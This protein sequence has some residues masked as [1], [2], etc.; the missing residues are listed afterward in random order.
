MTSHKLRWPFL[1][2]CIL[3]IGVGGVAADDAEPAVKAKEPT[4]GFLKMLEK[5]GLST[6]TPVGGTPPC[7][8]VSPCQPAACGVWRN[9]ECL[10]EGTICTPT[11]NNC[12]D[13]D[14]GLTEC[15]IGSVGVSCM[16]GKTIHKHIC[17]CEGCASNTCDD[18]CALSTSTTLI[19]L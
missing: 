3:V 19:C 2:T 8:P 17:S 6:F 11:N 18:G 13:V 5:G 7:P 9:G 1:L 15:E 10:Y 12:T 16:G 14:T 4:P